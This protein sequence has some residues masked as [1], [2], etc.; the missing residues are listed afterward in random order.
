MNKN[1]IRDVG[2]TADFA[3]LYVIDKLKLLRK[4][5]DHL[6]STLLKN[7]IRDVGSTAD[8]ADL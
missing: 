8:F 7:D 1:D 5:G 6:E 2:S 3:D 4:I